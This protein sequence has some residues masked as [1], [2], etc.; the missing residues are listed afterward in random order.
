MIIP[1]QVDSGKV[2]GKRKKSIV[3]K[4]KIVNKDTKVTVIIQCFKDKIIDISI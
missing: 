2:K 1:N 4:T 3:V